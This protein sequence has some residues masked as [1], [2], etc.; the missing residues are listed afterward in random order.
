[1]STSTSTTRQH[2][3]SMA[4]IRDQTLVTDVRLDVFE[5]VRTT[6]RRSYDWNGQLNDEEPIQSAGPTSITVVRVVVVVTTSLRFAAE[7]SDNTC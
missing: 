7:L 1:M 6:T 5:E 2:Q 4:I 3:L